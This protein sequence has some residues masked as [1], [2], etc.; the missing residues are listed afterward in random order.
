MDH[1]HTYKQDVCTG[2]GI[3][4]SLSRVLVIEWNETKG[5]DNPIKNNELK[6][7]FQ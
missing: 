3:S 1:R 6:L 5:T 2:A 7:R 4:E